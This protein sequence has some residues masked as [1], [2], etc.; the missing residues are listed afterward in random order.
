[1]V[2]K[3]SIVVRVVAVLLLVGLLAAAGIAAYRFGYTQGYAQG[4]TVT[5]GDETPFRQFPGFWPG[6]GH[7]PMMHMRFAFMPFA[8]LCGLFFFGLLFVGLLR[9]VFWGPRPWWRPGMPPMHAH[10]YPPPW[11]APP[12]CPPAGEAEKPEGDSAASSEK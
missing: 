3:S 5:A 7:F 4:A 1:M 8:G 12:W 10:G 11:G 6:V 2:R 9:L